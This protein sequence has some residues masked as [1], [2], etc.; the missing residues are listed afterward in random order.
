MFVFIF[1]KYNFVL[2]L[3]WPLTPIHFPALVFI[4]L[5]LLLINPPHTTTTP[6]SPHTNTTTTNQQWHTCRTSFKIIK[7][8]DRRDTFLIHLT[9]SNIPTYP[10]P[11][12]T[13]NSGTP[14]SWPTSPLDL[15]A[16]VYIL[17]VRSTYSHYLPF[18]HHVQISSLLRPCFCCYSS[19]G[20]L[21][22]C[23]TSGWYCS[24]LRYNLRSVLRPGSGFLQSRE[25]W[26]NHPG[27]YHGL[28]RRFDPTCC[29]F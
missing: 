11:C 10:P 7:Q 13:S 18:S 25:C 21:G 20:V 28:E 27:T 16:R 19:A 12:L 5:F 14:L 1:F 4:Y 22:V 23:P 9:G 26:S 8:C 29:S 3:C 17:R 6:L 2:S 15:T 24:F